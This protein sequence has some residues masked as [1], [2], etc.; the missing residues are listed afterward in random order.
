[1]CR[2]AW[3]GQTNVVCVRSQLMNCASDKLIQQVLQMNSISAS[4]L[5]YPLL[6]RL[7]TWLNHCLN[8]CMVHMY[9]NHTVQ[10]LA[11]SSLKQGHV[12]KPV[13]KDPGINIHLKSSQ[14]NQVI[15][16][17]H[18][19]N[20]REFN[21]WILRLAISPNYHLK[22]ILRRV[23][24]GFKEGPVEK[25]NK[26]VEQCLQNT[27]QTAPI[28]SKATNAFFLALSVSLYL[29]LLHNNKTECK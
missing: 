13:Y 21:Y 24:R 19:N 5:H 23:I 6:R 8:K 15:K 11:P 22:K 1:M 10:P 18:W 14:S 25:T 9:F 12:I 4:P 3:G 26:T 7:G 28:V 16:I 2:K 27:K 20:L 29:S 17:R